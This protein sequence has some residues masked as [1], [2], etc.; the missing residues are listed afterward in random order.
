VGGDAPA[1]AADAARDAIGD[2]DGGDGDGG[3]PAPWAGPAGPGMCVA[4]AP[5]AMA[6]THERSWRAGGVESLEADTSFGAHFGAGGI[7]LTGEFEGTAG[8]GGAP[9]TARGGQDVFLVSHDAA[10]GHRFTR[11]FGTISTDRGR[12]VVVDG[13]GNVT[14]A[15]EFGASGNVIDF[16]AGSVAAPGSPAIFIA[17]YDAA[18]G[19]RWSRTF[20]D[21]GYSHRV[22]GI[23]IDAQDNVY[24][25]GYFAGDVDF[26]AGTVQ[27]GVSSDLLV[28]SFDAAGDHRWSRTFGGTDYVRGRAIAVAAS[29]NVYV[30]GWFQGVTDFGGGPLVSASDTAADGFVLALDP[31]GAHRWSLRAGAAGIDVGHGIAVDADE[32]VLVTGMFQETVDLGGGPLTANGWSDFFVAGFD[33]QGRH[34]WSHGYGGAGGGFIEGSDFGEGIIAI[35]NRDVYVT[36]RIQGIADLGCGPRVAQGGAAFVLHLDTSGVF[37]RIVVFDGPGDDWGKA[38]AAPPGGSRVLATGHFGATVD[39]GGGPLTAL[40]GKGD[41]FAVILGP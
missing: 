39:F 3:G 19:H 24:V 30:T 23:A 25:A 13:A 33:A 35:G 8:F 14:V 20:G 28:A 17:S 5:P 6:M 9:A 12:G 18:G 38:I 27:A 4:A 15:G 32:R 37:R 10:G 29:G 36:G 40:G 1:A 41:M 21:P 7:V 2:G 16:G 26:G 22:H 31:A 11:T 34:L